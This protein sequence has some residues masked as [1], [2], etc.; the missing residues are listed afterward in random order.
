[1]AG[2]YVCTTE[3]DLDFMTSQGVRVGPNT[4][5]IRIA[6]DRFQYWL[7]K[8]ENRKKR[9]FPANFDVAGIFTVYD[10]MG[11]GGLAKI[12]GDCSPNT[13]FITKESGEFSTIDVAA[14]ELGHVLG[15]SNDG[16]NN[17]CDGRVYNV[18]AP[19]KGIL[20][21]QYA[22]N[23]YTFSRCSLDAITYH[24]DRVTQDPKSCFLT[25]AGDS[26]WRN[27]L[28]EHM[29]QL[30]GK[31]HSVNEQCSLYY[32]RGSEICGS[33]ENSNVCKML[34][35]LLPSTGSCSQSPSMAF[36]GTSCASGMM[37]RDGRCVADSQAPKMP[38]SCP[39]G[40]FRGKYYE[41]KG[42]PKNADLPQ[43]CQDLFDRVPWS[44]YDDFYSKR[45]CESCPKLKKKFESSDENCAYGDKLPP[46]NCERAE[47][48]VGYWKENCC[49]TC[50]A[51][52]TNTNTNTNTQQETPKAVPSCPNGE[53]DWCKEYS[54]S[55]KHNCYVNEL[56][57]CI[58]CPKLKNPSQVGCEYGDKM[59]WCAKTSKTNPDVCKTRKNDCC[60]SCKS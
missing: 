18:M 25:T 20:M 21:E 56:A 5:D 10:L 26:S 32:G 9:N 22:H 27:K 29:S 31:K 35:C 41:R 52:G 1:M 14:H 28:K 45:C 7:N 44:C 49:K 53:P 43:T 51:T 8:E 39:Y 59:S 37:C 13:V 17:P 4:I 47:C 23:L 30:L 50:S 38:S 11:Y 3:N 33:L 40:D 15:A 42:D 46:K 58:T 36:D 54:E 2:L 6:Y 16:E 57:C 55:K 19:I 60:F 48:K 12:G 34:S 24:L